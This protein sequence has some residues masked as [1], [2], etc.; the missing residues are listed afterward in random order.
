MRPRPLQRIIWHIIIT[1]KPKRH[2]LDVKVLVGARTSFLEFESN[3]IIFQWLFFLL[4]QFP[5][6]YPQ[7][8]QSRASRALKH[9]I[10]YILTYLLKT[11]PFFS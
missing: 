3:F 11:R 4:Y 5:D 6:F 8:D 9:T 1:V 10:L 7:G 2:I